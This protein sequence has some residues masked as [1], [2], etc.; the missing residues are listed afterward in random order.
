VITIARTF[1][2]NQECEKSC[3]CERFINQDGV[4]INFKAVCREDNDYKWFWEVENKV[5]TNEETN[6]KE[7]GADNESTT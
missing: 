6:T 4:E 7:G 5:A 3:D 2:K 1:C